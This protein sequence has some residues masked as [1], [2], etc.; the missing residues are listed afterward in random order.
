MPD[1]NSRSFGTIRKLKNGR[2]QARY[3]APYSTRSNRVRI[4]APQSF[5]TIAAANS[6]LASEQ[7]LIASGKW[8]HPK[9]RLEV[10]PKKELPS[11]YDFAHTWIFERTRSDGQHLKMRTRVEYERY[12]TTGRLACFRDTPLDEFTSA[13]IRQWYAESSRQAATQTAR[14]YDFLKSVLKTAVEDGLIESNPCT[15]PGGSKASSNRETVFPTDKEID[16]IIEL[17]IPRYRDIVRIAAGGGLRFGEIIALEREDIEILYELDDTGQPTENVD[18]V[19]IRVAKEWTYSPAEG[20]VKSPPKSAAGIRE[21]YIFGKDAPFIAA[22][23]F[24]TPAGTRLWSSPTKPHNPLS[25]HTFRP[26][27]VKARKAIDQPGL[28][29][30][31]LRHYAGTRYAQQSGASL[32]EIQSYLG[33]STIQAAMRYQHA[34]TRTMELARKAAR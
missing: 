31:D 17:I 10:K 32:A 27:W 34:G 1:K 4:S 28:R 9:E 6:W 5:P 19:I 18:G 33:H 20:W 8:T 15:V 29:F 22:K 30:H 14:V 2:F 25:Y 7:T 21:V 16:D 24:D 11:F 23:A 26:H 13:K 12:I 3:N